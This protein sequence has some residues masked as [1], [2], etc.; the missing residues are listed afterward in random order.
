MHGSAYLI[1]KEFFRNY[2]RDSF[3]S[4]LELGAYDM[5]GSLR[6]VK[7]N[8]CAYTGVDLESGPGVDVI[9]P[10]DGP[11]PVADASFDVA[12]C[13]SVFEHDRWFWTTIL[14]LC[15]VVKP[16]GLIYIN[17][18]SNGWFHTHPEDSWRFYPDAGLAL[19]SW[20]SHQGWPLTLLESFICE[21]VEDV[22]NDFVAVFERGEHPG[23]PPEFLFEKFP[24]HN[25]H[26]I[27][28]PNRLR[29]RH[30]SQDMMLIRQLRT[31]VADLELEVR[32]LRTVEEKSVDLQDD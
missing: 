12:V 17:S 24:A 8:S 2:W 22:W 16:G 10:L 30:E 26:A 23:T 6:S 3:H 9:K 5:N 7:P 1:G 31:R 21:Q 25:I 29:T 19:A 28:R 11:I 13:S 32:T 14:E 20:A 27:G 18:P 15:R 4:V